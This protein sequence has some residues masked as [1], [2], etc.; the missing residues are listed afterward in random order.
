MEN[1]ITLLTLLVIIWNSNP[2]WNLRD[3]WD[4]L[5]FCFSRRLSPFFCPQHLFLMKR[6]WHCTM[7]L[8]SWTWTQTKF[9]P[10]LWNHMLCCQYIM[11]FYVWLRSVLSKHNYWGNYYLHLFSLNVPTIMFPWCFRWSQSG[12]LGQVSCKHILSCFGGK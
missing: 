10:W 9:T 3:S 8:C 6:V 1:K 4:L 5:I 12:G 11:C 7:M 2:T